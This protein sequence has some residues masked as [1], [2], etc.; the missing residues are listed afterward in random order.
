MRMQ[1]I[2]FRLPGSC[3]ETG[4]QKSSENYKLQF[5]VETACGLL[6]KLYIDMGKPTA[7]SLAYLI[8]ARDLAKHLYEWTG[9]ETFKENWDSWERRI[10][11][12]GGK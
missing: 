10:K 7:E 11:E 4:Y 2:L 5:S 1:K 3:R 9:L 6:G 12:L 8:R